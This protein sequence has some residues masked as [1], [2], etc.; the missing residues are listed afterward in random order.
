MI[1]YSKTIKL[2]P[3]TNL[4]SGKIGTG[5]STII[6]AIYFCLYGGKK[7]QDVAN[8]SH[9]NERT[10][11]SF[12]FYSP[13]LEYIIIRTR[14]QERVIVK[15]KQDNGFYELQSDSAQAYINSI[16]GLED[17]FIASSMIAQK[18]NH[19]LIDSSNSEKIS[20]IQQITF[21]DLSQ[22]N[23]VEPY[24]QKIKNYISMLEININQLNTNLSIQYGIIDNIIKSN[25]NVNFNLSI[26]DEDKQKLL[27]EYNTLS[28]KYNELNTLLPKIKSRREIEAK[29]KS[30]GVI[31]D[32]SQFVNQIN[33]L[34]TALAK[35]KLKQQLEGFNDAVIDIDKSLLNSC[36]EIYRFF[37]T[38][39]WDPAKQDINE[40]VSFVNQQN[41]I[42]EAFLKKKED[43]DKY[44]RI[45]EERKAINKSRIAEYEQQLKL[46]HESK[47]KNEDYHSEI[48]LCEYQLSLYGPQ[49]FNSLEECVSFDERFRYYVY[50][51]ALEYISLCEKIKEV[52]RL[53][54]LLKDFDEDILTINFELL[55]KEKQIYENIISSGFND[56][57]NIEKYIKEQQVQKKL[58]E[59]YLLDLQRNKDI[60]IE[61]RLR[62]SNNDLLELQYAN[63]TAEY[64][65]VSELIINYDKQKQSFEKTLEQQ[66][67]SLQKFED[68]DDLSS[69]FLSNL[70]DKYNNLINQ[71]I[72]PNCSFGLIIENGILYKGTINAE[73]K[74]K[75]KQKIDLAKQELLKRKE[76]ERTVIEYNSFLRNERPKS[77]SVP[78]RPILSDYLQLVDI[79]PVEKNKLNVFDIPTMT[80]SKICKLISSFPNISNYHRLI[81]LGNFNQVIDNTKLEEC[82]KITSKYYK[83]TSSLDTFPLIKEEDGSLTI[84]TTPLSEDYYILHFFDITYLISIIYSILSEQ[85]TLKER[86]NYIKDKGEPII[87][88]L[89]EYP[90]LMNIIEVEKLDNISKPKISRCKIPELSYMETCNY[91]KSLNLIDVYNK[92]TSITCSV[93]YDHKLYTELVNKVKEI[94]SKESTKTNLEKILLEYPS[95]IPDIESQIQTMYN[96]SIEI[97]KTLSDYD[98]FK[99]YIKNVELYNSIRED[100]NKKQATLSSSQKLYKFIEEEGRK[101]IEKKLEDV[102][103]SLKMILD[104]LFGGDIEIELSTIYDLKDG[105]KKFQI[106]FDILYKGVNISKIDRLSGGE[107]NIVSIALLLSF[108]RLNSNPLL[109]MDEIMASL[110]G[111]MRDK[112]MKVINIWGQ[113]KFVLNICHEISSSYHNNIISI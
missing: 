2:V 74:D 30:I 34:D 89:V 72:C 43:I 113:D 102:N 16:F 83:S 21:G 41:D 54:E 96:R 9:K 14:P 23:Q 70:I 110:D 61:N 17:N 88:P 6:R 12:H 97:S 73:Q 75:Y 76:R 49:I 109:M 63:L 28:A 111:E 7:F 82:K 32:K 45:N 103:L 80:Y 10:E 67:N 53:K 47:K 78:S 39:G 62:K 20:L 8:D 107:E 51:F 50:T 24:L 66:L 87:Y 29:I 68:E 77:I 98:I 46:H 40:F 95:D 19:F 81:E 71:H 57:D 108:S 5:K 79:K 84:S 36:N 33:D 69:S 101:M 18:K 35:E 65:R 93:T 64:K 106:C 11:V 52:M 4:I 38:S 59:Q 105:R 27:E 92:Y 37:I 1:C 13:T 85:K 42:Y 48:K 58:Y 25:P 22:Y 56:L 26:T 60:E 86:L 15:I 3:G 91:M 31:E 55:Q 44:T 100:Y 112:C 94:D 90:E 104:E 99:N